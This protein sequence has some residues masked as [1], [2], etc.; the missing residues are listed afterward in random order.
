MTDGCRLCGQGAIF[1]DYL[2][3]ICPDCVDEGY[4]EQAP[5]ATIAKPRADLA[6]PLDDPRVKALVERLL[7]TAASLAA[8]I[9]LLKR[10]GK[11]A[12]ASDKM[13]AQMLVD[14]N[15]SLDRARA[16]L[17]EIKGQNDE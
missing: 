17:K 9:S 11:K 15:A 1:A 7:D 4:A 8:A 10:G 6:N 16:A 3:A 14:Y 13:F 5:K 2:G 12:A